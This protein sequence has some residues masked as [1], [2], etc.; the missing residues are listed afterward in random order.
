MA[1]TKAEWD[2]MIDS[3]A[4]YSAG[5]GVECFEAI[6][7]CM[8]GRSDSYQSWLQGSVMKYIWRLRRKET[9]LINAKKAQW[10]INKLVES[11]EEEEANKEHLVK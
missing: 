7:A 11:L 9:G 6:R 8:A 4:H 1:G 10:F 2:E 3:P 5:E